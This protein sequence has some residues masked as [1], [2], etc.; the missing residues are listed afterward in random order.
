MY[1]IIPA[2]GGSKG[3]PRKNIIDVGGYPLIAYT[4]AA[5]RLSKNISRIIV[6]TEDEEIAQVSEEF[7]AEVPFIRPAH[8]SEDNSSDVGF[9]QHFFDNFEEDEVALMRP[10]SPFRDPEIIDQSIIEYREAPN[11]ITGF[12]TVNEINENPYKVVKL[13]DNYFEGFFPEYNGIK[14]YT[15]LPRQTFPKAHTGNGYIDIVKRDTVYQ[16]NTFGHKI[17][18]C[19]TDPVVDIDS[20]FDLKIA[21]LLTL[22]YDRIIDMLQI[23]IEKERI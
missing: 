19:K 13:V 20:K 4:I 15:N 7:G 6:S 8:L 3:V 10:T 16:G 5:C 11:D 14:N 21:R 23:N 18:G 22:E 9:L 2:R 12:R 17:Y 1:A